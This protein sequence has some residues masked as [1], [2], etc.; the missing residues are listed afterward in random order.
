MQSQE[1]PSQGGTYA[2]LLD[3]MQVKQ[4]SVGKL[5]TYALPRGTFCYVGS[6]HGPGGLAG[7]I[8]R[9]MRPSSEKRLHWHI[10]WLLEQANLQQ[11]WWV[12]SPH[13]LECT[14]SQTIAHLAESPIP[15][16]GS[17]DC[18]CVSHLYTMRNVQH[19]REVF[20]ELRKCQTEDVCCASSDQSL[21]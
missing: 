13:L 4:M 7:R 1:I 18:S 15:G 3:R 20:R 5:G 17:S 6:A 9:H 11:V 12:E 21:P 14:W 2:L 8:K 19:Q 10:D 16:F